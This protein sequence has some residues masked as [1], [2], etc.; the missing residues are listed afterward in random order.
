[1]CDATGRGSCRQRGETVCSEVRGHFSGREL[2]G[3]FSLDECGNSLLNVDG[4]LA[5]MRATIWKIDPARIESVDHLHARRGILHALAT[6]YRFPLI[7]RHG[8][9]THRCPKDLGERG[10]QGI[11]RDALRALQFDYTLTLPTL[12]Q[13]RCCCAPDILSGYHRDGPI[14]RLKVALNEPAL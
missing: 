7:A 8:L 3:A 13:K 6:E 11:G 2:V 14:Q 5:S 12:L 1:M 9:D 10:G 4:A